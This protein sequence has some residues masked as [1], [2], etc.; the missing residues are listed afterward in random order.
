M[1]DSRGT[2]RQGFSVLTKEA[3]IERGFLEVLEGGPS[4]GEIR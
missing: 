4:K 2:R 1:T 3:A